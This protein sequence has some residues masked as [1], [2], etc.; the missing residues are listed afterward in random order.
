MKIRFEKGGMHFYDRVTG[1]HI[2]ADECFVPERLYSQAPSVVSIALTNICDLNC[3]FCYAPKNKHSLEEDSV[4]DWCRELDSLGTLEV[5][6]GGGEPTL[7]PHFAALCRKIWTETN[8]GIS[9][10]TNGHHLTPALISQLVGTVSIIRISIDSVEPLYSKLRNRPLTPV[11]DA[12]SCLA[13]R[14]P[15]GINTIINN[16]TL[17]TLDQMLQFVKEAGISDWLLLPQVHDGEFILTRNDWRRLERWINDHW[18]E[19]DFSITSE[20]RAF[21][22]CPFLFAAE[23]QND[24]AHISADYYLRRCSY[25]DGGILVR[26]RTIREGLQDLNESFQVSSTTEFTAQ[27]GFT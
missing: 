14:I 23:D 26:G 12:M 13:E 22:R 3:D 1:V 6:L 7:Y 27:S 21:V 19:V 16:L 24:Y 10:T 11:L 8:L 2:L 15:V 5:A 17:S 18:T 20:A 9:V 25:K 4:L